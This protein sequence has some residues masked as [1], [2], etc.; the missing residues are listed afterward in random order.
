MQPLPRWIVAQGPPS[1]GLIVKGLM[2]GDL[3]VTLTSSNRKLM[4][5]YRHGN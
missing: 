2:V 4:R 5:A 1:L 3:L